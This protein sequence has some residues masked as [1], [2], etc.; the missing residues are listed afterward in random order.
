[1]GQQQLLLIILGVVLVAI[2]VAVGFVI[3]KAQ[4]MAHNR[5]AVSNDLMSLG[6]Q[7]QA[8]YMRPGALG[9]GNRNFA[10]FRLGLREQV[11]EN[12]IYRVNGTG[13]ANEVRLVGNG[14]ETGENETDPVSLTLV[15]HPDTMYVDEDLTN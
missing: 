2:A 4:A 6:V 8:F 1:M 10:G 7:A 14:Y 3:F 5:D 9:G 12:G 11:N 13:D 15:V